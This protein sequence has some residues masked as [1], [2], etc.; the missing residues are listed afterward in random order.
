MNNPLGRCNILGREQRVNALQQE[1]LYQ[2]KTALEPNTLHFI[3]KLLHTSHCFRVTTNKNQ[4]GGANP[5]AKPSFGIK[6]LLSGF[7]KI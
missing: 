5:N 7:T 3:I 4:Y 1:V 2:V 6:K